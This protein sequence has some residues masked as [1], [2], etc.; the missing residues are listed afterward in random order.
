MARNGSGVMSIPNP[1]F[2][3]GTVANAD[4]IDANNT[5]IVNEITNSIAAD[6][7]TTPTANL[8]MGNFKHTGLGVGSSATDGLTLGQA[9]AEG[10]VWCGT[11]GGT[12]DA[13]TL[14]PAPVI[15]AYAAGQRFVFIGGAAANTGA[16]TV[17]VSGLVSKV[18]ENN[19]SALVA[20]D[21][22]VGSMYMIIY[23]GTAYQ[24][25][26]HVISTGNVVGP[27]AAT[28]FALAIF[29]GI[30]GKKLQD[31]PALGAV[32]QLLTSAGAG[33]KPAFSAAPG[34]SGNVLTSDGTNWNSVAAASVVIGQPQV[35][36][37]TSGTSFTTSANVTAAT[38]CKFT[39]VGAG[40]GAASTSASDGGSGAGGGTAFYYVSG[41]AASTAYTYAIGAAG[42]GG[43]AGADNVGTAGGDT[44]ITIGATTVTGAGGAGG[45]SANSE[46]SAG[47]TATNGTINIPGENGGMVNG[48]ISVGRGGDSMLGFG[49]SY[50]NLVAGTP[51]V[52]YGSGGA[53]SLAA[54]AGGNGTQGCIIVEWSE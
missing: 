15:T 50:G 36:F 37:L 19:G 20:D 48:A 16:T 53:G 49:G 8:K 6:G 34:A 47:G 44:S 30:T 5:D 17:A 46:G 26:K 39:V 25:T 7:Q 24:L 13:L 51:G 32:G 35:T 40:G 28:D 9:Q 45:I 10:F 2:V 11:A 21:I 14:S 54:S 29:D 12:A 33:V 31:G 23:D 27:A 52:G 42:V 38:V 41:L 1:D 22:A 18:I 3:P 43:A 4:P